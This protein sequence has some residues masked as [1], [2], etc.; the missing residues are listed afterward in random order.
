MSDEDFLVQIQKEFLEEATFFL[1]DCEESYLKLED[2]SVR[3]EEINKIF[4]L[5]HTLKGAGAAVGFADLS[6]FAHKVEDYLTLLKANPDFIDVDVI[7]LL[8]ACGDKLKERIEQFKQDLAG[9]APWPTAELEDRI[10]IAAKKIQDSPNNEPSPPISNAAAHGFAPVATTFDSTSEEAPHDASLTTTPVE[11]E[12]KPVAESPLAVAAL[13]PTSPQESETKQKSVKPNEESAVVKVEA[14]KVE[15]VLNVVGELVVLKSQLTEQCLRYGTDSRLGSIAAQMD[16]II[17]ELQDRTLSMRMTPLK[18]LFLK[19]QRILRDLSVK[20]AK[21]IDF[22][23]IGEEV[24]V[25]RSVVDLLADPMLHIARNA[26]DHGIEKPQVRKDRGKSPRGKIIVQAEQRGDRIEITIRD[27]GGG[28]NKDRIVA[29]AIE[30]G[31]LPPGTPVAEVPDSRAFG[32][33]F[34]PGFSTAEVVTDVSGRGVGMDVV[35]THIEKLRGTIRIE[36]NAGKGS[37]FIISLPLTAAITD[38]MIVQISDS[39]YL[40]PTDQIIELFECDTQIELS[41]D[42]QNLHH[43]GR[44]FPKIS[45]GDLFHQKIPSKEMYVLVK[46]GSFEV[47]LGVSRVLGQAQ[48]VLKS[49]KDSFGI[50]KGL[51]GAA[52]LGNGRV[53]L[54]IEPEGLVELVAHRGSQKLEATA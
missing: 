27:D 5:A 38:G 48:V 10:S 32:L 47:A 44:V 42:N 36:S 35:R 37:R 49:L 16:K 18:S 22:E 41:P 30:N 12:T 26:L 9:K 54:V 21:P 28:L 50:I 25:D 53:A 34:E 24:E 15:R 45:L 52:I 19:T 6:A 46:A 40:I 13:A 33:I 1:S 23:M 3:T 51:G 17:R 11:I 14:E 39:Q 4:R 31:I 7:T 20:F 29:K 8:L 43:R 2:A